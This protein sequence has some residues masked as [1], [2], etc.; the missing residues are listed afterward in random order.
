MSMDVNNLPR[1]RPEKSA[2]DGTAKPV[3]GE[4]DPGRDEPPSTKAPVK[5]RLL[6]LQE[7]YDQGL[8]TQEEYEKKRK[9]I[10]DEL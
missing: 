1:P 9:E 3:P 6:D 4:T 8:N 5:E 2:D 10:L 7:L